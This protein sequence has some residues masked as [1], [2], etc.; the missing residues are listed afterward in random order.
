M[1]RPLPGRALS[2]VPQG[3]V[4]GQLF[5]LI[6]INDLPD[7][8]QSICKIFANGTSLF[9]KCQDIK[10]SERELNE[11]LTIIKKRS[12][13][14]KMD[15]NPNPKKQA[16]EVCFSLKIVINN[17]SP[18]SL[19]QSQVKLS[20]SHKHLGLIPDTKLKFHEHLADKKTSAIE[21]LGP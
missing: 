21:L 14:W 2:G 5:L 1:V 15:F 6:Y 13:Q 17:P 16:I 20:E 3:S 4:L 18:L 9:S 12:F 19:N 7:C 11:G 10:K 8:N